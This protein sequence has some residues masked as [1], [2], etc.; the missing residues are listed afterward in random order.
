MTGTVVTSFGGA[1]PT[2]VHRLVEADRAGPSIVDDAASE[3]S[4]RVECHHLAGHSI[5][6]HREQDLP[7]L[8]GE[9][10]DPPR[11]QNDTCSFFFN[12]VAGWHLC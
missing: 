12:L 4:S 7:A 5:A 2:R 1:A 8:L 11:G 6:S 9:P 10:R 3:L